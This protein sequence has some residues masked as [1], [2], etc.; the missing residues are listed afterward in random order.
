MHILTCTYTYIPKAAKVLELYDIEQPC[1]Q[2]IADQL[3][4][5]TIKVDCRICSMLRF[6][7][8]HYL[9]LNTALVPAFCCCNTPSSV[10]STTSGD[11]SAQSEPSCCCQKH[12][13]Q[14]KSQ[15]CPSPIKNDRKECPCE[16]GKVFLAN[17]STLS[18]SV[19]LG[20]EDEWFAIGVLHA[21]SIGGD[22][23]SNLKLGIALPDFL[24]SCSPS[25]VEILRAKC[26]LRC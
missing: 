26:V 22:C 9:V 11:D 7:L 1:K 18:K 10:K 23:Q 21:S 8:I 12:K 20:S 15:H 17:I 3:V 5:N 6:I 4:W 13:H 16:S 2:G 14:S 25:S 19:N 24:N